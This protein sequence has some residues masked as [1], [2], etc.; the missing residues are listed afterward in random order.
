MTSSGLGV[1]RRERLR[2]ARLMLLFSPELCP[3]AS[4]PL[5]ILEAALPHVDVVQVR[6]KEEG[7]GLAPA[8]AT[9]DWTLRVLE[10]ARS[11][12][13]LVL[14]NDRPDVA[15]V[16]ASRGVAGVHLGEDDAPPELARALLGADALLGLS[17]HAPSEVAAAQGTALDYLGF[18]PIYASSTKATPR[19]LGPEVARLAAR[20]SALPVFPI[21]GIDR[22]NAQEL[23]AI[24]RAAVSAAILRARDPGEA[25]AELRALLAS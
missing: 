10:R 6:V 3:S 18:G 22:S 4:D 11:A 23:A 14:V 17:T 7:L 20:D 24:G 8:R 2:S 21:G 16:L 5:S 9:Y 19:T 13:V 1:E 12:D 15:G 25:A